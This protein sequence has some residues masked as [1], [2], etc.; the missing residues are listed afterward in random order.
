MVVI[1]IVAVALQV[2]GTGILAFEIRAAHVRW[3]AKFRQAHITGELN[4]DL[5]RLRMFATGGVSGPA[6]ETLEQR[7]D[8]LEKQQLETAKNLAEAVHRLET[9]TIPEEAQRAAADVEARLLP[10][11]VDTLAYLAGLG[12]RPRWRPWWLGPLLLVVGIVLGG[13][14]AVLAV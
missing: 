1:L 7:L 11:I 2:V 6:G 8:R 9:T 14:A 13:L 4:A 3:V 5:P 12:E 10:L